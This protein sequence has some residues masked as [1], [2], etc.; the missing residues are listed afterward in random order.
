MLEFSN[1]PDPVR[2]FIIELVFWHPLNPIT[3]LRVCREWC[4]KLTPLI[5]DIY[6]Y[7]WSLTIDMNI[8]LFDL[9]DEQTTAMPWREKDTGTFSYSDEWSEVDSDDDRYYSDNE[10]QSSEGDYNDCIKID[11][12]RY[13]NVAFSSC[14]Q[15][16][17]LTQY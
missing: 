8:E 3:E 17:R 2:H 10:Y 4:D 7:Q 6:Y 16:K 5:N 14:G 11:G 12:V 15:I 1:L 13:H 9:F